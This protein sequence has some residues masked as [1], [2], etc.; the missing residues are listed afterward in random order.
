MPTDFDFDFDMHLVSHFSSTVPK[1]EKT[2]DECFHVDASKLTRLMEVAEAAVRARATIV[3]IDFRI[4]FSNKQ[5]AKLTD[6]QSVLGFDNG[7]KKYIVAMTIM[8]WGDAAS[9]DAIVISFGGASAFGGPLGAPRRGQVTYS[10]RSTD[11]RW[12]NQTFAEVEEQVERTLRKE[13]PY[14][15][16]AF[17]GGLFGVFALITTLVTLAT[18]AVALSVRSAQPGTLSAEQAAYFR[19]HP[20]GDD[21][22]YMRELLDAVFVQPETAGG[23]SW[24]SDIVASWRFYAISAPLLFLAVLGVYCLRSCYS[25]AF[26]EWGDM[27][28]QFRRISSKRSLIW[29]TVIAGFAVSVLA[30]VVLV[31]IGIE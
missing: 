17:L 31:A 13:L 11:V 8:V 29:G 24:V 2:A 16:N 10:T 7:P 30:G 23:L 4:F 5:R 20:A 19:S 6:L 28:E 14:R 15:L 25:P 22:R 21:V 3:K 9:G 27:C 26:F 18:S 12:S 1:L